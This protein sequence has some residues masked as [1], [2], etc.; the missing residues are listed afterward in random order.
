MAD[1]TLIFNEDYSTRVLSSFCQ[2][3]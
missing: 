3:R 2:N 1:F